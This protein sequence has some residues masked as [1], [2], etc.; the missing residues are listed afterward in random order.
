[1]RAD[2]V[3]R[4]LNHVANAVMKAGHVNGTLGRQHPKLLGGEPAVA[5]DLSEHF[6]GRPSG[7]T[8][9]SRADHCPERQ[10]L[11]WMVTK[12]TTSRGP[13]RSAA[14]AALFVAKST[15]CRT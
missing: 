12:S 7:K 15:G 1:M 4:L 6:F 11:S 8:P 5:S 2:E 10:D 3:F 9:H 13:G 14:A